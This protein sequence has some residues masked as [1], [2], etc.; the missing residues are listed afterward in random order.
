MTLFD[1]KLELDL[2]HKKLLKVNNMS[3]IPEYQKKLIG[4]QTFID[5]HKRT[6]SARPSKSEA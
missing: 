4:A 5:K 2:R 1:T 6:R 3:C